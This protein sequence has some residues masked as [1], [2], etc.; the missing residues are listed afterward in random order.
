MTLIDEA[1]LNK[2]NGFPPSTYAFRGQADGSWQLHS[3][4]TRRLIRYLGSD[5]SIQ[6]REYARLY[7]TYH[8]DELIEP[9]RTAGFGVDDGLEVSDLQLLA[10]LQHFGAATGLID[11]TW[12]PLV[13]LWFAC[14]PGENDDRAGKV[15]VANLNDPNKFGRVS[16]KPEDQSIKT[17]F[18]SENGS[19]DR[20]FYWEPTPLGTSNFRILRQR[21]VFVIGRPLVPDNVVEA[22]E[23]RASDKKSIMAELEERLD[24]NERTLFVDIHGFSTVNHADAPIRLMNDPQTHLFR[25]NQLSQQR[26]YAKAIES[27]DRCIELE[28]EVRELYFLRGSA[29]AEMKDYTGAKQDYDLAV[30]HRDRPYLNWGANSI[31][32]IDPDLHRILFNRA[33]AKVE[34]QDYEGALEDYDAAIQNNPEPFRT[35]LGPIYFNRANVKSLLPRFEDAIEDYDEAIRLGSLNAY[36]NKGNVLVKLGRFNEALQCYDKYLQERDQKP[37]ATNTRNAIKEILEKIGSRK[38]ET[39]IKNLNGPVLVQIAGYSQEAQIFPFQGN[40]GNTGNFGGLGL[41]GGDGYSGQGGFTVQVGGS[42]G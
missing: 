37:S 28:S 1:F 34:L 11:F 42:K 25:G 5:R 13:A 35:D 3:S 31:L 40:I 20:P 14:K 41:R 36:F 26:D 23:I 10:K 15:F 39:T 18:S 33:N 17:I 19:D 22:I 24:I 38:F 27:Y 9:A 16:N 32:I 29:K 7:A 2:I 30:V 21:S 6:S 8:T 4:A 12:N